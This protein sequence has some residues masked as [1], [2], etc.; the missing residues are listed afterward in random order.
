[1]KNKVFTTSIKVLIIS[2]LLIMA[3]TRGDLCDWLLIGFG[4]AWL[5]FATVFLI[6]KTAKRDDTTAVPK[7]LKPKKVSARQVAEMELNKT[8]L[9][10]INYRITDKLHS[11]YPD[12]TWEWSIRNPMKLAVTGGIGRIKTYDTGEYNYAEVTVDKLANISFNM[13]KVIPLEMTVHDESE[14]PSDVDAWYKIRGREVFENV[15]TELNTRGHRMLTIVENGDIIIGE[16]TQESI[17]NFPCKSSWN[18]LVKLL[19]DDEFD[20]RIDGDKIVLAW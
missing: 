10:H 3:F 16:T 20:A 14:A 12:A 6:R 1:M 18:D 5:I 19:S 8:L 2:V 15:V 13:L 4:A 9:M 11:A 7:R 17:E